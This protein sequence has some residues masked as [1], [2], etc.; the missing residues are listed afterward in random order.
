MAELK[1]WRS[2][3]GLQVEYSLMQRTPERDLIPMAAEMGLALTPWAPLAGGALTGKYL[4]GDG[5]RVAENSARR[6]ERNTG[7]V[8]KVVEV[9]NSL[10]LSASQVAVRWAMQKPFTS[11]PIVGA[12]T[13]QQM[14]ESLNASNIEIPQLLMNEL[15]EISKIELGFPHDFLSSK[16]VRNV[17]FGGTYD[18][19]LR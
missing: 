8:K 19:I 16:E 5:G 18:N 7:I 2:F 4:K 1:G 9:A 13:V 14:A 3:V 10:G 11:I 15:D 6:N 12:R 17:I